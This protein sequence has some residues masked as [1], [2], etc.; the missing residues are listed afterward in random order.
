MTS[1]C[2]LVIR[3]PAELIA[4]VPFVMG[5]HPSD[6][7]A[8]VA[9]RGNRLE[10]ALCHG[11]PPPLSAG[12]EA[13]EP[14][15]TVADTVVRQRVRTVV[16]IG[17]GPLR[18]VTPAVL[19]CAEALRRRDVMVLDAYRVADGRWWSF[20]CGD[21]TCCPPE[22]RPCLPADSVIAAEATFRGQ[23]ALPSRSELT[24][25][26]AAAGGALRTEM[27][28]ATERARRRF[29]GLLAR[30]RHVA[31]YERLVRQHGRDAVRAAERCYRSGGS[32]SPDETAWLGALLVDRSVE[33]FALDR[34]AP[35]EW[36]I[37]LWTDVLRRVEPAYVAPAACLLGYT[38]WRAGRGSLARV[39]VDRAL[40][41][42]PR[43]HL[44]ELLHN[45]LGFGLAPHM[46]LP[47][48]PRRRR[49]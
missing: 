10:F 1:D 38:A 37:R 46:V 18:R 4:M 5:Y 8:V 33:D 48:A 34:V 17:Y 12:A 30:G 19:R 39:A 24:A 47:T 49:G 2:S 28:R 40:A 20:L 44:A 3:T 23:V 29:T 7:L 11:L 42:D 43:H 13:W 45:V 25:Q 9:V 27:V 6:S 41:A 22:G 21:R 32:L 31:D 26:V 15:D 14:A 16:V 36:R 35:Q